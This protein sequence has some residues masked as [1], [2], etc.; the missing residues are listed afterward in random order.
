MEGDQGFRG[1]FK[2]SLRE[3]CWGKSGHAEGGA[4]EG[5]E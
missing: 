2:D 1:Q 3:L 4:Q 5:S